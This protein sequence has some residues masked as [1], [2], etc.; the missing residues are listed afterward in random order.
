MDLIKVSQLCANHWF[1]IKNPSHYENLPYTT[2][3]KI[4]NT[5]LTDNPKIFLAQQELVDLCIDFFT[6]N[7]NSTNLVLKNEWNCDKILMD[8]SKKYN[9]NFTNI[10]PTNSRSR[11]CK[12]QNDLYKLYIKSGIGEKCQFYEIK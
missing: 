8:I 3:E 12:Q 4:I 10:L 11:I 2:M 6:T 7:S 5:S 1:H 9:L